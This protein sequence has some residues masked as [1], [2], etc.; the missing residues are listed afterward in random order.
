MAAATNLKPACSTPAGRGNRREYRLKQQYKD[1]ENDLRREYGGCQGSETEVNGERICSTGSF[2][3]CNAPW[4]DKLQTE[5]EKYLA[6][7]K[8]GECLGKRQIYE[9]TC[10]NRVSP[11]GHGKP[12]LTRHGADCLSYMTYAVEK[13]YTRERAKN[14]GKIV[15]ANRELDRIRSRAATRGTRAA[16]RGTR[17][18]TRGTRSSGRGVRTK[19]R[20]KKTKRHKR[21]K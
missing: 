1:C 16:T 9:D 19:K 7:A 3:Y 8:L 11:S 12:Y 20:G 15:M 5:N 2:Q 10:L 14:I 17:A 4:N 21:R 13:P 6:A 18:A